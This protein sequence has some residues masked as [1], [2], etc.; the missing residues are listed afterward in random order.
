[1]NLPETLLIGAGAIAFG[2]VVG[3]LTYFILRRAKP[4]ALSDLST[5]IATLG[6]ATIL[7]LFDPKGPMFGAYAL[8]LAVGFFGYYH[9]YTRLVGGKAIRETLIRKQG[10]EGTILE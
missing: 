6:G 2:I 10:D 3:W 8:G 1:L 7:G 4:T 9:A 5:V